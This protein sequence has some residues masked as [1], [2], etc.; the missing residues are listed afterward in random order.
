[1]ER[2]V[3]IRQAFTDVLGDNLEYES[4]LNT[5]RDYQENR[6][7]AAAEI[8][9]RCDVA[10]LALGEEAILSGE[11]HCRSDLSLPGAQLKLVNRL[12][13]IG[14]PIVVVVIAGHR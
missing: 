13:Q 9:E 6:F 14:K 8:V 5:T 10:I 7:E 3:S 12:A 4:A 2:S 1:M 11:A